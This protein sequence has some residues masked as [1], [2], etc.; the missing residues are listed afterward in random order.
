MD[1]N[2]VS[3]KNNGAKLSLHSLGSLFNG[4]WALYKTRWGVL[5]E[6]VLLPVLV[7]IL[8]YV[9]I[10]LGFPF[11][12]FGGVAILIGWIIFVFSALPVVYSVHHATG[13]DESYKVTIGWFWPFV[14]VSI[15]EILAVAGGTIMLIVPGIWLGIAFSFMAYVFVIEGRKGIDALRQSKNYVKGYWWPVLGR[16]ILLG[17]ILVVISAIVQL[18]FSLLFGKTVSSI[19]SI[20]L[21]LFFVPFSS[22]YSYL[23]FQNLRELKPHL[24]GEQTKKGTGFIKVSAIVGLVVPII[25]VAGVIILAAV[26]TFHM[27][28]RAGSYTPP[29]GYGAQGH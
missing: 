19:V 6:I 5:S 7:T 25:L 21:I 2:G 8:G 17:I 13:V 3:E 9:L 11:S 20:G 10:G 14:W 28:E 16:V 24:V 18:P 26:G 22:I 29:P 4:A 15:L 23:I 12:V 27:F 1:T